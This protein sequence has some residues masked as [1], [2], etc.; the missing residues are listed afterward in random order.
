MALRVALQMDP[1][2]RLNPKGDSTVVLA[3][4]AQQRGHALW[5]YPADSL[6]W[7]DDRLW[8][9]KARPI[10][11]FE[12]RDVWY[13]QQPH[14]TLCLNEV[15]VVLMRQD[16]PFDMGYLTATYLLERIH[17]HTLVANDPFHVRNA[18][19]KLFPLM[20]AD[21]MP[22]TLITH[23]ASV[24]RDFLAEQGD[25]VVKPVYGFG[26]HAVFRLNAQS[27]NIEAILET[28]L[29]LSEPL[30]AQRFLPEVRDG[31]RR[32]VLIDGKVAGLLGRIPAE[33][34]I[35]ANLRVGGAAAKVTLTPR[36]QE[37]CDRLTPELQA[38]GLLFAGVDFIGDWLTEI[39]IT[40]PTGLRALKELYGTTPEA[41]FWDAI[42]RKR[43]H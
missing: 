7:R 22:P 4:E 32:V 11:F 20:F 13:E 5:W 21:C 14:E 10:Q 24:I 34:E 18:P 28:L 40:S 3:L 19:E 35:R 6:C 9:P 39:N 33:G 41:V 12:G 30:V 17:P 36:Q 16:P 38:R 23:E 31:D 29:A 27:G 25:I 2:E 43:T 8:T 15:D 42:E 1:P 26:G 37:I